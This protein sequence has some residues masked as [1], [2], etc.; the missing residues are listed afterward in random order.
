MT[1]G[2]G[3]S[4]ADD[5]V[6][7]ATRAAG[8]L[9]DRDRALLPVSFDVNPQPA[10][11]SSDAVRADDT[12]NAIM[13]EDAPRPD[14]VVKA[15]RQVSVAAA[16]SAISEPVES[17][18]T[19]AGQ[20]TFPEG[21]VAAR[22]VDQMTASY[23]WIDS[24]GNELGPLTS[25]A[26]VAVLREKAD[27]NGVVPLSPL[28]IVARANEKRA[29]IGNAPS[30]EERAR[31]AVAAPRDGPRFSPEFKKSFPL[32]ATLADGSVI[33]YRKS[34]SGVEIGM[35]K[36]G[37][38]P[39]IMRTLKTLTGAHTAAELESG[40]M[41]KF[42]VGP[43]ENPTAY[44][45]YDGEKLVEVSVV[46][47]P[48]SADSQ[49]VS[50]SVAARPAQPARTATPAQPRG[51]SARATTAAP[52][53]NGVATSNLRVVVRST[54]IVNHLRT[55]RGSHTLS[56]D[57]VELVDNLIEHT[58]EASRMGDA[59]ALDEIQ[60][61]ID[62]NFAAQ[63]SAAATSSVASATALP[64]ATGTATPTAAPAA[65][66]VLRGLPTVPA[67]PRVGGPGSP[68]GVAPAVPSVVPATGDDGDDAITV[69]SSVAVPSI[70]PTSPPL[71]P[72]FVRTT[73]PAPTVPSAAGTLP[74]L[75]AIGTAPAGVASTGAADAPP[76]GVDR[77]KWAQLNEL[78]RGI[79]A[80]EDAG[81]DASAA[82]A[83]ANEFANS[84]LAEA[85]GR[86]MGVETHLAATAA[87]APAFSDADIVREA[88]KI[89]SDRKAHGEYG[90]IAGINAAERK[91]LGFWRYLW[92][93]QKFN[94]ALTAAA[95]AAIGTAAALTFGAGMGTSAVVGG[96]MGAVRSQLDKS[97]AQEILLQEADELDAA[98][99]LASRAR[100]RA[101]RFEA[102][103]ISHGVS[104][105]VKWKNRRDVAGKVLLGA[106]FAAAGFAAARG[107][108]DLVSGLWTPRG[109]GASSGL[110]GHA[111]SPGTP[112][113]VSSVALPPPTVPVG[114]HMA[115]CTTMIDNSTTVI[116]NNNV[117]GIDIQNW[118]LTD[119]SIIN[120][121]VG[122]EGI[123]SPPDVSEGLGDIVTPPDGDEIMELTPPDPSV[124][125]SL[126]FNAHEILYTVAEGSRPDNLGVTG[127]LQEIA[128]E[129]RSHLQGVLGQFNMRVSQTNILFEA[130][131]QVLDKN[132]SLQQ[133][134]LGHSGLDQNGHVL[135]KPGD[136]LR[137]IDLF[138][139]PE[140]QQKLT[141]RLMD[142]SSP[143]VDLKTLRTFLGGEDGVT[144]FVK[145]LSGRTDAVRAITV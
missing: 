104:D 76:A 10:S 140:F 101:L 102:N 72:P 39:T 15:I 35:Q 65:V 64:S 126:R 110:F 4:F 16:P 2:T 40:R 6:K 143:E 62:Q 82:R 8:E 11:S 27:P 116:I 90:D 86:M 108:S 49:S 56:A 115:S 23:V 33:R 83:S 77:V 52:Q 20:E 80:V 43:R 95:G 122:S 99:D 145:L 44:V 120:G 81:L 130:I 98:G 123:G 84:L 125:S 131:Q 71:P 144:K 25:A 50:P 94:I 60:R 36:K 51:Q 139:N 112:G 107:I 121:D 47:T 22:C 111:T 73:P 9:S 133:V 89:M 129:P 41:S 69:P 38:D 96:A 24:N 127:F 5:A 85:A 1:Q 12:M 63:Q 119:P 54:E 21:A 48:P 136:N 128:S 67:A 138:G 141:E 87:A 134:L 135:L 105:R 59:S 34:D 7:R 19:L 106:G 30:G 29:A 75:T 137:L 113:V 124:L 18:G 97:A 142:K 74:S 26:S 70:A 109:G 55:L 37:G 13:A 58:R 132:D 42:D 46:K 103:N 117:L 92:R 118:H 66:G 14:D 53:D 68:V 100:A 61:V 78:L 28:E 57:Q 88:D 45:Y 93:Y 32:E 31:N 79:K 17:A 114:A 3:R 91:R